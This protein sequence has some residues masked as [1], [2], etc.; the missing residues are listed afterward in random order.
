MQTW[1]RNVLIVGA[2]AALIASIV[3][4]PQTA[5][6]WSVLTFLGLIA[7]AAIPLFVITIAREIVRTVWQAWR[8][9]R[10]ATS[11]EGRARAKSP[12]KAAKW[13]Q[14]S[15]FWA[16]CR[17]EFFSFYDTMRYLDRTFHHTPW[18][19]KAYFEKEEREHEAYLASIDAA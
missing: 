3:I 18:K 6:F 13:T 17:T 11:P 14:M 10:W 16:L 15:V 1:E 2:V 12:E 19:E 5:G 8:V 7:A 9:A 4:I